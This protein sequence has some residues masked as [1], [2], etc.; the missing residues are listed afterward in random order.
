MADNE[1]DPTVEDVSD[2]D[3]L[4]APD[5]I[6]PV[7]PE[8]DDEESD[9][10]SEEKPPPRPNR[11]ERRADRKR[12]YD[13]IQAELQQARAD[14]AREQARSRESEARIGSIE[15][16]QRELASRVVGPGQDPV[17]QA[18]SRALARKQDL[19][20]RWAALPIEEQNK[21]E[22]QEPFYREAEEVEQEL[23]DLRARVSAERSAPIHQEQ[24]NR[25]R[26]QALHAE[27]NDV[28]SNPRAMAKARAL[29]AD[30]EADG[31][32][33]DEAA[34]R[35][36]FE[37]ARQWLTGSRPRPDVQREQRH[38]TGLS[39]ARGAGG[40][41]RSSGEGVPMTKAMRLIAQMQYPEL[42]P[43]KAAA[44]WAKNDYPDYRDNLARNQA[45]LR[46]K[47]R[48]AD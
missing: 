19:A 39:S 26:V 46:R 31:K 35:K 14:L 13:E 2:A 30:L 38:T 33:V 10:S 9:A 29:A 43:E 1:R 20:R 6:V 8:G 25:S 27:F 18:K 42:T 4:S 15:A 11:S 3:L 16:N 28:A 5:E 17:A 24:M 12:K 41:E 22:V 40:S 37:G 23:S 7:T 47:E 34:V 45:S 36:C 32:V 21:R 48:S 44:R